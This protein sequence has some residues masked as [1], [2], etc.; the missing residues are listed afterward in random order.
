MSMWRVRKNILFNQLIMI[1]LLSKAKINIH[2]SLVYNLR[3]IRV[4]LKQIDGTN[5][6]MRDNVCGKI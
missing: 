1:I 3:H 6:K 4:W 5:T 2:T